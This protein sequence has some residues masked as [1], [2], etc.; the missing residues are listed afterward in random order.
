MWV[1]ELVHRTVFEGTS[2]LASVCGPAASPTV[3]VVVD[4]VL[5]SDAAWHEGLTPLELDNKGR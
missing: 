5:R 2:L 3:E 1:D 4:E